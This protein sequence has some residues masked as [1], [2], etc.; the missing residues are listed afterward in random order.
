MIQE[1]VASI[2]E[3]RKPLITGEDGL[4]ALQVV[5]AAYESGKTHMPVKIG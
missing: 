5:M 3:K 2:R 4:K 1:F